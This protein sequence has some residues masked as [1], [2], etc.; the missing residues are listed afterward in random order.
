MPVLTDRIDP[1]RIII[2]GLVLRVVTTAGFALSASGLWSA[3]LWRFLQGASFAGI[4]MP[5]IKAISDVLSDAK[6]SRGAAMLTSSYAMGASV[7][8]F[9]SRL[10]GAAFDWR[11]TYLLLAVGPFV[12]WC[13]IAGLLPARPPAQHGA[14]SFRIDF[15]R[16]FRN[17]RALAYMIAYSV[18]NGETSIMRAWVV[19]YL[20]FAQTG[21]AARDL[22]LDWS[23]A[24][25]ATVANVLG[26]PAT[27]AMAEL[28]PRIGRKLVI[29]L[30]MTASAATGVGLVV[31]LWGPYGWSLAL[32]FFYGRQWRRIPEPS[33][34]ASGP[35]PSPRSG[36]RPWPCTRCSRPRP[37]LSCRSCSGWCWI[38]RAAN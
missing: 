32:V 19:A 36:A 37:P 17:R 9:L 4:Y 24:V 16:V 38:S 23:P 28:A 33:M 15:R 10:L 13:L 22:A 26:V 7:S 12:D 21:V 14:L 18:H 3:T 29:S 20:I 34:A 30:V 8:F 31:A 11:T 2:A 25:V 35:A 1:R 6:R 5:S 27:I